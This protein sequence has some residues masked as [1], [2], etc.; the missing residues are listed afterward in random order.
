MSNIASLVR[1]SV[2]YSTPG[3][4]VH[5][6][7]GVS[8]SFPPQSTTAI[9]GRSG[10][11]KSTLISVLA[12]LRSPTRGDVRLLGRSVGGLGDKE[13][14]YLRWAEVGVVF[15]SF[16]LEPTLSVEDNIAL[17]WYLS[18]EQLSRR[19]RH[20]RVLELLSDLGL[21]GL[22]DRK[23]NALSGGQRQRVAI[24]RALYGS[25]SLV[26][27]DEPTGNLDERT[28]AGI[29]EILFDCASRYGSAVVVVTHDR[30]IAD[31]AE[32]RLFLA[33]GKLNTTEKWAEV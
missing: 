13:R 29:G 31:L 4:V 5:A 1:V 16:H 12:L 8:A 25:P 27:A 3:G 28:A 6:L 30:R 21:Q 33:E 24:A 2:D 18:S 22:A 26:I 10:S 14:S 32:R 7:R 11:G 15:Q 23:P 20:E 17:P 19:V 9:L